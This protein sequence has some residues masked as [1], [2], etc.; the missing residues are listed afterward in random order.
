LAVTLTFLAIRLVPGDPAQAALNQSTAPEAV[1][2]QRRAA[3]GLDQPG[4]VQYGRYLL[5]LAHA[6]FG[7]SWSAN[8]PVSFL[9][10]Q[11]LSPTLSLAIAGTL[12]A[13]AVGTL[14]GIGAGVGQDAIPGVL[15]RGT[16]GFLLSVP[17]MFS[18][19]LLIAVFA[20][21]FR[22]LP[23]TGQGSLGHL[24][25]PAAAV[26]LSGAGGIARVVEAGIGDQMDQP[27]VHLASA[28][29]LRRSRVMVRHA[30]RVGLLPALDAIAL[31]LGYLF[32]GAVITEA[33]FA[34]QGIGR[35]LL[36]AV[37][38]KDLPLVQGIV[39]LS[40]VVYTVVNFVADISH[41]LLDPRLRGSVTG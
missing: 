34:R 27:F 41:A 29:G 17:V 20:V 33:V 6:D 31:Q 36:L 32:G 13:V 1:L 39:I 2:E 25:L 35:L 11:Q 10:G 28:K 19:M 37:L 18:G 14:L 16:A 3:L 4:I 24:L 38:D 22:L 30:L 8:Q 23:G 7:L 12:V 26:G 9:I 40:V 5:G 21:R 15:A